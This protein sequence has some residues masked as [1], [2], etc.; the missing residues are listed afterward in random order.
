MAFEPETKRLHER[1]RQYWQSVKENRPFPRED[2]IDPMAIADVWEYCFLV[3]MRKGRVARGFNYEFMGSELMHAYGQ[4]MVSLEHCGPDTAPHIASMLQH[5]DEVIE[6]GEPAID[7]SEFDNVNGM[8]IL[9][10]CC[11]L[12]LGREKPEYILG[13]MRWKVV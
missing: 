7:E 9:Y 8:R 11:L 4:N 2:E 1:V 12:P 5:L 3:N 6:S 10:R 13:C